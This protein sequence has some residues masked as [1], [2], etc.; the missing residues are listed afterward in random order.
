MGKQ[1]RARGLAEAFDRWGL[2]D[3][4]PAFEIP[5]E[6]ADWTPDTLTT[7]ADLELEAIGQGSLTVSP[8]QMALVV[9]TLANDGTK[10]APRLAL[11]IKDTEGNWR[12]QSSVGQPLVVIS[13]SDAE[14]L[15]AAWTQYGNGVSG[16][17][18]L[19]MAG[20]KQPPHAWFLGV[21]QR[22]SRRYAVAVLLEHPEKPERAGEIGRML[23][24]A[25]QAT[26]TSSER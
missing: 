26:V 9:G 16:H 6:A 25:T 15:L 19:A 2:V 1:L 7:T 5:T 22:G 8:L 3:T 18:G 11:R 17:L 12:E 24:E 23:L 10:P 20:Q 13:S 14:Y 4:P 21:G